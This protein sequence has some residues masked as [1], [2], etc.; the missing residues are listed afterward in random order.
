MVKKPSVNVGDVKDKFQ[1]LCWE[2]P[3]EEGMAGHSSI[4]S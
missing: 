3:L 2:D 1:S 4:P